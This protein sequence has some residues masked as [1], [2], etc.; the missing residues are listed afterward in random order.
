MV[1]AES[2]SCDLVTLRCVLDGHVK[3]F[4]LSRSGCWLEEVRGS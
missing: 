4:R 3:V 1:H 2:F